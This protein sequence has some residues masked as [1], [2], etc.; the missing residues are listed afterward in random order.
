MVNTDAY[1][2]A[3]LDHLLHQE[4]KSYKIFW[5]DDDDNGN[6]SFRHGTITYSHSQRSVLRVF[7]WINQSDIFIL[8]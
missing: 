2:T 5:D 7:P 8:N 6:D 3:R 1:V 4:L